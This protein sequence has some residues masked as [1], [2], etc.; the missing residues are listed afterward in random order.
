M[1]RFQTRSTERPIQLAKSDFHIEEA[2]SCYFLKALTDKA[3][4]WVS[5]NLEGPLEYGSHGSIAIELP[6]I[7]A[8]MDGM[9]KDG[10]TVAGNPPQRIA[11]VALR[12]KLR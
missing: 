4:L 7:Q 10:L 2:S 3:R 12:N 1:A 5:D 11:E 8:I 9:A 6:F